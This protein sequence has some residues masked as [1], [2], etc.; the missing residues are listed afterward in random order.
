M[1]ARRQGP[2]AEAAA[3]PDIDQLLTVLARV[4]ARLVVQSSKG[5]HSATFRDIAVRE[6]GVASHADVTAI[7]TWLTTHPAPR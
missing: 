3:A 1:A 6:L 2:E 7:E 5:Q 4:V